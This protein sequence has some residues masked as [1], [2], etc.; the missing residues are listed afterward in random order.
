MISRCNGVLRWRFIRRV[1]AV[2]GLSIVL[3]A[4][5]GSAGISPARVA[6]KLLPDRLLDLAAA[7][8]AGELYG[9]GLDL[10]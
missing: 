7:S 10:D 2:G 1:A 9:V 8:Q 4:C 3:C 6:A 5:A